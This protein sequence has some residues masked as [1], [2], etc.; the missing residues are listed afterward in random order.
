[1][2]YFGN[3]PG[4]SDVYVFPLMYITYIVIHS[5][6]SCRLALPVSRPLKR[7]AN[8]EDICKETNRCQDSERHCPPGAY[9]LIRLS[10]FNALSE[11]NRPH[12]QGHCTECLVR[13]S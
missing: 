4:I 2:M 12:N 5:G 7:D 1:M 9:D 6:T 11:R 10:E 8:L 3:P 13:K